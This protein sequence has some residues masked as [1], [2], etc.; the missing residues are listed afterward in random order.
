M[1]KQLYIKTSD[2]CNLN[3]DHCFTNGRSGSKVKWDPFKTAQWLKEY[4]AETNEENYLLILHGG[5]PMLADIDHLNW[6]YD[7]MVKDPRVSFTINTNLTYK[8]TDKKLDFL[9]RIGQVGTSWDYNIRFENEKQKKLWRKNVKI[10]KDEGLPVGVSVS[11]DKQLVSCDIES[12]LTTMSLWDVNSIRLER[13][14]PI[15]NIEKNDAI[16]PDNELVDNW[17]TKLIQIYEKKFRHAGLMIS[18]LDSIIGKVKENVVKIDTNCRNCEQRITTI[19]ADGSLSGCPN[20]ALVKKFG[21]IEESS[22]TYLESDGRM[23]EIVKELDFD[24][25]CLTCDV[26]DLCGGDCHQLPWVDGRCGGIK[27]TLR[28]LKNRNTQSSINIVN[29]E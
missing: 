1:G 8:L 26:F 5:E 11:I 14:T 12:L 29:V 4:I 18:T 2:T 20:S 27:N 6:F 7:E 19:S 10:L 22:K 17:F 28:Y 9:K 16:F 13:L 24:V 23:N 15:G 21:T 3:C 25:R